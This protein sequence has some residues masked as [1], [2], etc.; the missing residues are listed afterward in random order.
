M[1]R[2]WTGVTPMEAQLYPDGVPQPGLVPPSE[3]LPALKLRE[4]SCY[5]GTYGLY[6]E[7]GPGCDPGTYTGHTEQAYT[8]NTGVMAVGLGNYGLLGPDQQQRYTD[9]LATLQLGGV[10]EQP[11]AMP[12]IGPSPDFAANVSQP[13]NER[14]SLDQAWGTYGVL[15]PVVNQQLGVDPQL[16]NGLLEVLPDVP[17]GQSSVS[18]TNIRVGTGSV[19]VAATHHGSSYTT[20]VTASLACTLHVGATLPAGATVHQV[21]LNGSAAHYTVRDTNAGREVLVST[22]CQG[23]TWR[24]HVV[25]G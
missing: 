25:A 7:G 3:A 1:Q 14:S 15:W 8:L 5:S 23:Q 18:G 20:T 2:W 9:D 11:G 19:D 22:P 16:G 6:V 4:T 24:V 21:T 13:F 10:A 17:S 12:E